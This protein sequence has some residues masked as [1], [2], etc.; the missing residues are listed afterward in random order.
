MR[1]CHRGDGMGPQDRTECQARKRYCD[2][3]RFQLVSA[4]TV[5]QLASS[6]VIT[7]STSFGISHI[8]SHISK[9]HRPSHFL[10][11]GITVTIPMKY[12]ETKPQWNRSTPQNTL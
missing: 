9:L 3:S 6:S 7:F 5:S 10:I 11:S 12:Y 2:M 8:P 4:C 1:C